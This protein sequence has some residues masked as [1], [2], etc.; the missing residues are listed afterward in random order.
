M[1]W[2]RTGEYMAV[3]DTGEYAVFCNYDDFYTP[4]RLEHGEW[5]HIDGRGCDT[6]KEAAQVCERHQRGEVFA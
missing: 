4:W 1:K 2:A 6:A 5:I 3:S